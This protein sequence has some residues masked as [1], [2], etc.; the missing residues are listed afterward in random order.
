[1]RGRQTSAKTRRVREER[2][3]K[4]RNGFT[5]GTVA[6]DASTQL[7]AEDDRL[8]PVEK[9]VEVGF[10]GQL[11]EAEFVDR[12]NRFLV[13]ARVGSEVVEAHLPDPGRL[14]ELL[15]PGRKIWLRPADNAKR[16]TQWSVVLTRS[17]D[18]CEWVSLDSTLPNR[19]IRVALE[20]RALEEF[21]SWRLLRPEF[22]MG[23]HRFDFLLA[24]DQNRRQIVEVKSVTLVAG[25]VGLFP[26]AVTA[27]GRR[28]LES[29]GGLVVEGT[30]KASVLFVAQ[31]H[32][33]EVIRAAD[34]IDPAFSQALAE[35]RRVGVRVLARRCQVGLSG[36]ELGAAIPVA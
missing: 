35:A 17:L 15:Q 28:H 31:R 9:T 11:S 5:D 12:P 21:G 16:R 22:R 26:D 4:G 25:K 6:V 7:V 30:T 29:L 19:L 32:D 27:R 14:R 18:G 36:L 13:R 3:P 20:N 33:V 24:D 8:C 2:S 23:R 10:G 1:M 34:E